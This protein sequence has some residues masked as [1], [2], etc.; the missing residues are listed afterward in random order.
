MKP[1]ANKRNSFIAIALKTQGSLRIMGMGVC[2]N[3]REHSRETKESKSTGIKS[4]RINAQFQSLCIAS[5]HRHTQGRS[6]SWDLQS[7]YC[8]VLID[9][10]AIG[11]RRDSD[12]T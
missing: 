4:N 10:S 8:A 3:K 6:H 2:Q 12:G 9:S 7:V 5:T 11:R 1:H